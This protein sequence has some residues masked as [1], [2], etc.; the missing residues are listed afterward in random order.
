MFTELHGQSCLGLVSVFCPILKKLLKSWVLFKLR[1]N[2]S[3]FSFP[4]GGSC[5]LV[6]E[7]VQYKFIFMQN[8][9]LLTFPR[10]FY[11]E[12]FVTRF[13][14]ATGRTWTCQIRKPPSPTL[15]SLSLPSA[16]D[17]T[18]MSFPERLLSN[19]IVP[20]F[21]SLTVG[22]VRLFCIYLPPYPLMAFN[23]TYVSLCSGYLHPLRQDSVVR[24]S[25]S[26]TATLKD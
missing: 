2:F 20:V 13:Y 7:K 11:T 10:I 22:S 19:S 4:N 26:V 3:L 5:V 8:M 24:L 16:Y 15:P 23:S 1:K 18:S 21:V 17:V 12:V 14:S 25:A 9:I 6:L